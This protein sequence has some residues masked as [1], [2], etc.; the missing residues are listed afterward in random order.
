[1]PE[2]RGRGLANMRA[3]RRHRGDASHR[4]RGERGNLRRGRLAGGPQGAARGRC[5][6][7][8]PR[9]GM[10]YALDKCLGRAAW[11]RGR[12]RPAPA[13]AFEPV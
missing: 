8:G 1:M 10:P 9:H 13:P 6:G 2:G 4:V 11:W 12:R 7:R 5:S 3:R